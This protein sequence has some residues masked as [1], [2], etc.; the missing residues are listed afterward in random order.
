[1]ALATS[2]YEWPPE[3]SNAMRCYTMPYRVAAHLYRAASS[4]Y[5]ADYASIQKFK[6][7]ELTVN[8]HCWFCQPLTASNCDA[9]LT[10]TG[11]GTAMIPFTRHEMSIFA[12]AAIIHL[13]DIYAPVP[14]G[15]AY[16]PP[17]A[18][19]RAGARSM[20]PP[21]R[22]SRSSRR[23]RLLSDEAHGAADA[24]ASIAAAAARW[25]GLRY[26]SVRPGA[27]ATY[28]RLPRRASASSARLVP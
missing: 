15:H 27:T 20:P 5:R 2:I 4:I 24:T 21:R 12:A 3:T 26:R 23:R 6:L 25:A 7:R 13:F 11:I 16:A 1:M 18:I 28:A 22:E 19:D 10:A 14:P 9:R 17:R 8:F